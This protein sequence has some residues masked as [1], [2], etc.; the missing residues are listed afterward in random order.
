MRRTARGSIR[1]LAGG[2]LVASG[3]GLCAAVIF[4][5]AQEPESDDLQT[6][7]SEWFYRQ[8]AFPHPY[9]PAGAR[10]LALRELDAK[11]QAET[12]RR[13]TGIT[14][15]AVASWSY[16]GPQPIQTP[17]TDPIVSGRVTSLAVDPQNADV[18]YLGGAQGGV[19]KTIDGGSNWTPLTDTQAST[20][21]GSL[22]LDPANHNVIYAGTGEENFS[23]DSY[24]GAGLLKS[25]DA[26]TTW[27]HICWVFCG[28]VG[29]DGFYG[30]G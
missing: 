17:Y 15:P 13:A 26:G 5:P 19:W 12:A 18:V 21:I 11:L 25:T 23:G 28:P 29:Q 30:G 9:V 4:H 3:L 22:A 6:R 10:Q 24:Y 1:K 14:A 27:E 20:A 16:L 2:V 7:R 8:R